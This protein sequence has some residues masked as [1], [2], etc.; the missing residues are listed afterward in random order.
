MKLFTVGKMI[1]C[2]DIAAV[3]ENDPF[4]GIFHF[5]PVLVREL[6]REHSV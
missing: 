3:A 6:D 1:D 5:F 4:G 2:D